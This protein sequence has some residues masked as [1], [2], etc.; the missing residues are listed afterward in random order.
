MTQD[1]G[2][3][4]NMGATEQGYQ[5]PGLL[6]NSLWMISGQGVAIGFQAVYFIL[7]GR[8]L[9]SREYGV[10]VGVASLIQILANFSSAGME[11]VMVRDVSRDRSIFPSAWG[12][13]VLVTLCGF[14]VVF[15]LSLILGHFLLSPSVLILIPYVCISDA[16]FAKIALLGSRAFQG[17][18]R[19]AYTAR[20]TAL[21]NA[22]RAIAAA[23][24]F[25]FAKHFHTHP[26]AYDWTRIYWI[27]SLFMGVVS[28]WL[29]TKELGWPKFR[30]PTKLELADGFSFSLSNSSISIYNDI[31]KTYLVSLGQVQAA[32][33][34]SAAYRIVDVASSPL[35]GIYAAAFPRFFQEGAKSVRAAADL[36]YRL[37]KRTAIYGV[38]AAA[39]MFASAPILPMMLGKSFSHSVDALRWLCFLP[40]IRCF[41]YAWGTTITGSSPQWIRTL[42]QIG[43]ALFNLALNAMLIPR[44]SWQGAA[45]ASL[46]TD[47]ALAISN[48]LVVTILLSREE[49]RKK[50]SLLV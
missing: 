16:L 5:E 44:W 42:T 27:S 19:L 29:V 33:I 48:W 46:A 1:D 12:A 25:L 11:M 24:L 21:A 47:G 39:A 23:G 7:I 36:S 41:H 37:L 30:L 10:F 32:G 4:G 43:A 31:D 38:L 26:N 40:L 50:E 3:A 8:T 35:Y 49:S 45:I 9:G 20:L 6:K 22:A 18:S 28:F 17:F 15:I 13:S 14:V 34:Y 2:R